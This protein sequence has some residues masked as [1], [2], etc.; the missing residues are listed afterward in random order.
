MSIV[1]MICTWLR[2]CHW[3]E[4][5]FSSPCK[6]FPKKQKCQISKMQSFGEKSSILFTAC[7]FVFRPLCTIRRPVLPVNIGV[8][9][10][11]NFCTKML[12]HYWATQLSTS[13]IIKARHTISSWEV[14]SYLQTALKPF[15]SCCM[16]AS[17]FCS[18]SPLLHFMI[19]ATVLL[20]LSLSWLP[21]LASKT[22][23]V[24]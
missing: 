7:K 4:V 16:L 5:R 22:L 21:W 18:H 3:N 1:L 8:S 19:L 11:K 15:G 9:H 20:L 10:N 23:H 24:S 2:H 17:G 12:C 6:E 14:W 13:Y